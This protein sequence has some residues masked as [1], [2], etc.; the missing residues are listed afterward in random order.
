MHDEHRD[1]S[2][3][4]NDH[5]LAQIEH[6]CEI[7]LRHEVRDK[8]EHAVRSERKN[9]IHDTHDDAIKGVD[10]LLEELRLLGIFIAQLQIR[11][12]HDCREN[13]DRD[14]GRRAASSEIGEYVR[15]NEA[16]QLLRNGE[17]GNGFLLVLKGCELGRV[18]RAIGKACARQAGK[19]DNRPANDCR[20]GD[21]REQHDEHDRANLAK[22][23]GHFSAREG[24]DNGHEHQRHNEHL[25]QVDVTLAHDA[26]PIERRLGRIGAEPEH[27]LDARAEH[28]AQTKRR[29]HAEREALALLLQKCEE[30]DEANENHEH[31]HRRRDGSK[32]HSVPL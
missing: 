4:G 2:N 30:G 11:N 20:D 31:H 28:H 3:I 7:A 23:I 21:R 32:R 29:E 18:H 12:A 1:Q 17:R 26:H 10:E 6:G 25:Q 16:E 24:A 8:G 15:R 19:R 9:H 22:V 14:G 13:D 27:E 5:E